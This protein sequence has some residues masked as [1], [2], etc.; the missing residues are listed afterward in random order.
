L[1]TAVDG[2]GKQIS[3]T[4]ILVVPKNSL[5]AGIVL[6]SAQEIRLPTVAIYRFSEARKINK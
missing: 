1:V 6:Q 4:T 5:P 2:S 3:N